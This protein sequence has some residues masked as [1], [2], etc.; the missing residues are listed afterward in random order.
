MKG[1]KE[2]HKEF[3]VDWQLQINLSLWILVIALLFITYSEDISWFPK[4]RKAPP[5]D[6]WIKPFIFYLV[7]ASTSQL[8]A[9]LFRLFV[10]IYGFSDRQLRHPYA[11]TLITIIAV[12]QT[13]EVYVFYTDIVTYTYIDFLGVKTTPCLWIEW[14]STVPFMF[15]LTSVIDTREVEAK[16]SVFWIEL[17]AGLSVFFLFLVNFPFP[18][19]FNWL[20]FV[21]SNL[22]MMWALVY[23]LLEAFEEYGA[24]RAELHSYTENK[25]M[26]PKECFD[27]QVIVR[28]RLNAA[29]FMIVMFILIPI[30]YY[31]RC[32]GFFNDSVLIVILYWMSYFT[33]VLFIHILL[34]THIE[35]LDAGKFLLNQERLKVEEK[36]RI[37]TARL[38]FLRYAFHEVRVPLNS[39]SLG[40]GLL[41]TEKDVNSKD[42][43]DTLAMMRES[44]Y[45]MTETLNDVLSLQKIEQG[46]FEIEC[47]AFSPLFLVKHVLSNFRYVNGN[48]SLLDNSP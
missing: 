21:A 43:I 34:D 9:L 12:V 4:A 15:F 25:L 22:L 44:V 27:R 11:S 6:P 24:A 38:M 28:S 14:L 37:D 7:V 39:I 47:K 35:L 5:F 2:A 16:S 19:W 23:Q 32:F 31:L 17:N 48:P 36:Q 18:A 13:I 41:A 8:I 29:L 1:K 42:F 3:P 45:F 26:V 46:M 40:I 30:A 10:P 33:K 20:L